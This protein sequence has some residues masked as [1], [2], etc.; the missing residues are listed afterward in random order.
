MTD[1]KKSMGSLRKGLIGIAV[2]VLFLPIIFPIPVLLLDILIAVNLIFA[3][4]IFIIAL[5]TKKEGDFS[6]CPKLF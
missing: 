6:L 5:R 4:P 2:L 1:D 3:M